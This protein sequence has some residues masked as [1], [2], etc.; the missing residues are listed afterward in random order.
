MRKD[1]IL[2]TG[3]NGEIGHGLISYFGKNGAQSIVTI[4]VQPLDNDIKP[5]VLNAIQGDILDSNLLERLVAEYDIKTIFHLASI[6]SAATRLQ[7]AECD[8]EFAEN[9]RRSIPLACTPSKIHLS[10][11][12]S[13][14]WH[15]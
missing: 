13:R 8:I 5:F 15:P 11:F 9:C 10:K 3:A 12:D 6:L 14:L 1:I 2:I 4:D 7:P